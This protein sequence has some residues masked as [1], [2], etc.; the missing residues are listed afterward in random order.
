MFLQY[1]S[2]CNVLNDIDDDG[3]SCDELYASKTSNL[4]SNDPEIVD[5]S[6]TPET[7]ILYKPDPLPINDEV[8]Y[9]DEIEPIR[10]IDPVLTVFV[11]NNSCTEGPP[12]PDTAIKTLPSVVLSANSPSCKLVFVGF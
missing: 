12:E 6:V 5:K 10:L 3:T 1:T 9:D 7:G 2:V 11:T 4:E 8:T